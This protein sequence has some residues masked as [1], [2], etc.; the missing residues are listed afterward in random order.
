M[1]IS[2]E[3]ERIASALV[4]GSDYKASL[5]ESINNVKDC[6]VR[7]DEEAMVCLHHN[8]SML[9][10]KVTDLQ[11]SH[12][13]ED[14]RR[15]EESSS[16]AET[17]TV[18]VKDTLHVLTIKASAIIAEGQHNKIEQ[19]QFLDV[20][21]KYKDMLLANPRLERHTGQPRDKGESGHL[22]TITTTLM[23][24]SKEEW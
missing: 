15:R 6:A 8:N 24:H 16:K 18:D 17:I 9:F 20:L 7:I 4:F 12:N 21:N 3:I 5:E 11:Q 19:H 14:A 13:R 2:Y 10:A 1:L 22:N 23:I